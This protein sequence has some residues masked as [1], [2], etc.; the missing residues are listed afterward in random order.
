MPLVWTMAPPPPPLPLTTPASIST[1]GLRWEVLQKPVLPVEADLPGPALEPL[2][3]EQVEAIAAN[4][5]LVSADF[6]PLLRLSAAVPT[7]LFLEPERWRFSATQVS[8]FGSATGTGNQNYAVSLDVGLSESF[9]LSAY[10]S[11]ADDPLNAPLNG[12]S[13]APANFWESYAAAARWRLFK[14]KHLSIAANGS[15]EIWNVGSGGDDSFARTGDDASPNIFNNSGQRV[16]TSNLVGSLTLPLSWQATDQLQ[17]SVVPGVSWLPANQGAGQGGSGSFYGTT[18]YLAAGLLWQANQH[19][20]LTATFA[21]P[22]GS[23]S[24]SFNA[25]LDFSR[26]PI[27]SA[28]LNW[29]LNPRIGLRGQL[30]NGFG[31]TPA[32]ALL[33]LPSDN[34]LGYSASFVFTPDGPDTPQRPLTKRQRS[35]AKGGLTV[36]SALVPPDDSSELWANAD[37]SGNMNGFVGYSLSNIF[38]LQVIGGLSNDVPQTTPQARLFANDGARNLRIGGK[39]VF[40]SPLRGAPFWG[41]GRITVGR[42]FD[43]VNTTGQG[44]VFAETMATWEAT[45]R[46]ALSINPK[47]AQVGSGNLWGVGLS[48]NIQLAPRWELVPEC[49]VVVNNLAQSNGTLGLRWHATDNM[50]I[51]A[52]GSTAASIVDIGQLLSAKRVRWGGRVLVSF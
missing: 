34:R 48:S 50:A 31:A 47:I 23:G 7:A 29:D 9:Q 15:L 33:A 16:F 42:N 37:E 8:P 18:P 12:F 44:Y 6:L 2:T 36:N 13:V 52:Y 39:A 11:Q 30:T 21:Q 17:L 40:F 35:L 49:N 19:L 20:G 4:T 38:Q 3:A 27:Y 22:I 32:T 46:L 26:V 28:G 51:E 1:E 14:N 25:D 24:N 5:P 43:L 45:Q 41:G 10:Y